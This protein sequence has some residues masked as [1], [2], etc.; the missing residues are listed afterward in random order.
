MK[1]KI[2]YFS[3]PLLLVLLVLAVQVSSVPQMARGGK[4]APTI[5]S[6]EEKCERDCADRFEECASGYG[7]AACRP[8]FDLCRHD[9]PKGVRKSGRQPR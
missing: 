6:P 8:A 3:A 9:S 5:G 2:T 1:R 4:D 7:E